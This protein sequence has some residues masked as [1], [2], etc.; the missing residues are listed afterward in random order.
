MTSA[1]GAADNYEQWLG[2]QAEREANAYHDEYL[3]WCN[4]QEEKFYDVLMRE[5]H[6][7]EIDWEANMADLIARVE[8][9]EYDDGQDS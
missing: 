3:N 5:E 2:S 9:G 7:A 1:R 8:A 4:E 6:E